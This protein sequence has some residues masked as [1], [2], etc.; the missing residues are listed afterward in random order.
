MTEK[1]TKK[2]KNNWLTSSQ[3]FLIVLVLLLNLNS[4]LT[5]QTN[6]ASG[7]DALK[8]ITSG[9]HNSGFGY[10]SLYSNTEGVYNTATG[11]LSLYSNTKGTANTAIGFKALYSNKTGYHNIANGS[12]ALY[13][14]TEGYY[15]V[16]IGSYSLR[17][18][19]I[20]VGNVGI[21]SLSLYSNKAGAG[22]VASGYQSLYFNMDGSFNVGNGLLS[23]YSNINGGDNTAIG[24]ESL[25]LNI[26][27]NYNVAIGSNALYYNTDGS[28]NTA[29]G[30]NAGVSTGNLTN[31]TA[32]GNGAIVDK[33]N[34]VVIGNTSVTEIGGKVS[35]STFSDARFKKNIDYNSV[36]GM[37]FI[38]KL[39][40][41]TYKYDSEKMSNFFGNSKIQKD[42]SIKS[43][44]EISTED[45]TIYTGFIAQEVQTAADELNYNFSGIIKPETE[46]NHYSLRY[47]DFVV[48]MVKGMQ[49]QQDQIQRQQDEI[50]QLKQQIEELK[51]LVS[52]STNTILQNENNEESK[53]L[54]LSP[55]PSTGIVTITTNAVI[56]NGTLQ[57]YNPQGKIVKKES[58]VNAIS[59]YQF[60]LSTY[61]RGIY[62]VEIIS[63]TNRYTKKLILE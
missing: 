35:W 20:G 42:Q 63:N 34:K 60:N 9:Y 12:D 23:L 41:A 51:K 17:Y 26:N 45:E 47:S 18:N 52:G 25:Y 5:A 7:T 30:F 44:S 8:S 61:P 15:N 32:I 62:T 28:A 58:F 1:F 22:N 29:V 11:S 3:L 10:Q 21:G 27:G 53:E 39:K 50:N 46:K 6:T 4:K 43:S 24:H 56:T 57:I 14:N 49:E 55:N 38:M 40:P 54:T 2:S 59:G 33:S 37:A 36:R 19:T 13:S 48:P 16:A 31:A